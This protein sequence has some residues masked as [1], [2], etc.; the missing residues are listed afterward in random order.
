M[1]VNF[2]QLAT[3]EH[4]RNEAELAVAPLKVSFILIFQNILQKF[5]LDF[6][7]FHMMM[8]VFLEMR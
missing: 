2:L 7:S 6:I 8:Y 3:L 5:I 4:E 1:I